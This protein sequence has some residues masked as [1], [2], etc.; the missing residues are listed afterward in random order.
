MSEPAL[1][2]FPSGA[3]ERSLEALRVTKPSPEDEALQDSRRRLREAAA[4]LVAF[5]PTTLRPTEPDRTFDTRARVRFLA[6]CAPVEDAT[7]ASGWAITSGVRTLTLQGMKASNDEATRRNLRAALDANQERPDTVA[8]RLVEQVVNGALP[9]LKTLSRDQLVALRAIAE[10]LSGVLEELPPAYVVARFLGRAELLAPLVRLG[11]EVFVGRDD[12]MQR[13]ADHVGALRIDA[14]DG[15]FTFLLRHSRRLASSVLTG[16]G[17]QRR[18][19]FLHG[20][21]GVGKST[22]LARFILSH[23]ADEDISLPFAVLDVDR[24]AVEPLRPL[25]FL[26]EALSQLQLQLDRLQEPASALSAS[27]LDSMD[28]QETS[29]LESIQDDTPELIER[30]ARLVVPQLGD[31]PLLFV[32]DTFEE[33]QFLGEEVVG[34]VFRFLTELQRVIPQARIVIS[35]RVVPEGQSVYQVELSDL[36][37]AKAEE[38]VSTVIAQQTGTA[39]AAD[40]ARAVVGEVGSNPMVL[41]LAARLAAE[42]DFEALRDAAGRNW[43]RRVRNEAQQARLFGRI[44]GHLHGPGLNDLTFPGILVRRLTADVIRDVLA[45]PCNLNMSDPTTADDLIKRLRKEVSLV[46]YDAADG[47]LRYKPEIR[48]AM[49][50]AMDEATVPQDTQHDINDRAVLYWSGRSGPIARAEELYHRLRL[51][52]PRDILDER[53]SADAASLL[54]G[55]FG[56]L[57]P[58]AETWL[59]NKMGV[60]LDRGLRAQTDQ[61]DWEMQAAR[62]AQRLLESGQ[63]EPAL[64]AMR[65]RSERREGSPLYALEGRALY[66]LDRLDEAQSRLNAGLDAAERIGDVPAEVEL[67]LLLALIFERLDRLDDADR[68]ARA[69]ASSAMTAGLRDPSLRAEIR[70]L[71]LERL[72][73]S[74]IEPDARREVARRLGNAEYRPLRNDSALLRDAA[75]E[76]GDVDAALL[77]IALTTI[78]PDVLRGASRPLLERLLAKSANMSEAEIRSAIEANSRRLAQL[79]IRNFSPQRVNG[80]QDLIGDVVLAFREAC[81]RAVQR[82][83]VPGSSD[84][85]LSKA[86]RMLSGSE[87]RRLDDLIIR[88]FPRQELARIL[89]LYLSRRIDEYARGDQPHQQAVVELLMAANTEGWWPDLLDALRKANPNPE[90]L[91]ALDELSRHQL[92]A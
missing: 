64:K 90:L 19:L 79:I 10:W 68:E 6:D 54:R 38:L 71:R 24:P 30:F 3:I 37:T 55:A 39:P 84:S 2:S 25:T 35:G 80:Q 75:A 60:T 41:R 9:A 91:R 34:I 72:R 52:Q 5:D 65:E 42:Q 31:C 12:E 15:A 53:W 8:Q 76:L 82:R 77:D 62:A 45:V 59:A 17:G 61:A 43:L 48:R 22:L 20:P 63:P 36:P 78:G 88:Y 89:D 46:T 92:Q 85:R 86:S 4:L 49:L 66:A 32:V 40:V 44:L 21:G 56:E 73:D 29:A 23:A 16:L 7:A 67:R 69:A 47:S 83:K 27:I 28:G 81:D 57:P 26:I 70:L 51:D 87:L 13:L 50:E 1:R 14:S 74:E 18:P 11:G 33:V 58:A